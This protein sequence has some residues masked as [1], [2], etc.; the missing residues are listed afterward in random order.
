MNEIE[1]RRNTKYYQW[2]TMLSEPHFHAPIATIYLLYVAHMS[3]AQVYIMEAVMLA[4]AAVLQIPFGAWAD[5]VGKRIIILAG[6]SLYLVSVIW[7]AGV[8]GLADAWIARGLWMFAVALR[9]GADKAF[10][11]DSLQSEDKYKKIEGQALGD[12]L[13]LSAFC[14]LATGYL[15]AMNMRYPLYLSIPFVGISCVCVF[16]FREPAQ[17]TREKSIR[18]QIQVSVW[19]ATNHTKIK[20]I[21]WFGSL[22]VVSTKIWYIS[23]NPYFELVGLDLR[24]YGVVFFFTN[25]VAWF[26]SRYAHA[27]ENAIGEQNCIIGMVLFL[28]IPIIAMG[29]IVSQVMIGMILFQNFVR[30]FMDP[31][32]SWLIHRYSQPKNRATINSINKAI[33]GFVCLVGLGIFS[34]ILEIFPLTYSLQILGVAVL[35]IGIY[36]IVQYGKIFK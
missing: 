22:M 14:S 18:K 35:L 6:N 12:K 20:W 30:G 3:L 24:W 17:Q 36:Q 27:I 21:I 31:F 25:V 16:L 28:G 8:D 29:S 34:G 15:A 5:K 7:L 10:L 9:S 23:Y 13:L 1:I 32:L 4:G 26:F 11:Y 19:F 2:F 33:S